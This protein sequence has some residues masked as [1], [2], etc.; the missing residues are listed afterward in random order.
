MNSSFSIA[1][2]EKIFFLKEFAPNYAKLLIFTVL[3]VS[4]LEG[5]LSSI[6]KN[7]VFATML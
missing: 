4:T 2:M 6:A 3:D 5:F 1:N 7:F